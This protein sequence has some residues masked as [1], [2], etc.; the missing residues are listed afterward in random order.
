MNQLGF[1][2]ELKPPRCENG[3]EKMFI[4]FCCFPVCT[5]S[6]ADDEGNVNTFC[7]D[8][9]NSESENQAWYIIAPCPWFNYIKYMQYIAV[10]NTKHM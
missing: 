4:S 2:Y 5:Y 3:S 1:L 7:F 9:L 10:F 6:M 8:H